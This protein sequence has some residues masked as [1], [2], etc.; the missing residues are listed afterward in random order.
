[1]SIC[2]VFL[3]KP[4]AAQST[5]M[6]YNV[7]LFSSRHILRRYKQTSRKESPS[8]SLVSNAWPC[9]LSMKASSRALRASSRSYQSFL[10]DFSSM[11]SFKSENTNLFYSPFMGELAL[12]VSG[13]SALS[14][15]SP[16]ASSCS[17]LIY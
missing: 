4:P 9:G 13:T 1:M 10:A 3:R 5:A 15:I 12:M 6:R 2:K 11:M 8:K 14:V 7:I 16:S 17:S